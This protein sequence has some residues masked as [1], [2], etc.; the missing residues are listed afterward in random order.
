MPMRNTTKH[1]VWASGDAYEPSPHCVHFIPE[2]GHQVERVG[3]Y[4][5]CNLDLSI[6]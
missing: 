1:G 3:K 5:D 4:R 6:S 2:S